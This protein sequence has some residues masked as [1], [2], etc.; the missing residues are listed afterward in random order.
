MG[1][2]CGLRHRKGQ[3]YGYDPGKELLPWLVGPSISI[4][5]FATWNKA[6]V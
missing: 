4:K 5:K 3:A 2:Q 1:E 6:Y